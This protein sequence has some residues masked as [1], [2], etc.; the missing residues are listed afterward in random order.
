MRT[1]RDTKTETEG[2]PAARDKQLRAELMR[3]G[4]A[5]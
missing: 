5:V 2:M 3:V 4:Y 1:T